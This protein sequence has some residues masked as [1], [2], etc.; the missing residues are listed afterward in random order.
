MN[1]ASVTVAMMMML[2]LTVDAIMG[3][4]IASPVVIVI[5]AT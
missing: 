1:L 2:L 4:G 5:R 3:S